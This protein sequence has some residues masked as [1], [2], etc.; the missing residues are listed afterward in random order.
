MRG[1][2]RRILVV[3]D[4]ESI[5]RNLQAYLV[6]EGFEV[7]CAESG[8][9][10]LEILGGT[11]FDAVIVDM[12]LQGMDGNTFIERAHG[13][14]SNL[15][16]LIYTGSVGYQPPERLLRLGIGKAHVFTKPLSDMTVL[17]IALTTLFQTR[18]KHE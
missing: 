7:T 1:T 6:D 11:S 17:A 3:D 4:E 5:R 13:V 2:R 9:K 8:E 10:A 15:G 18:E 16:F 12:R 14:D